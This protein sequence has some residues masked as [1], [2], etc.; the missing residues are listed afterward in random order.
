[1]DNEGLILMMTERMALQRYSPNTIK[2]Y[3]Q[4]VQVFLRAMSDYANL[5][6]IP[7]SEIEKFINRLVIDNKISVSYQR[8]SIQQSG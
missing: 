6:E 1:M 5:K 4:H 7:V 3:K 8:Q 2:A